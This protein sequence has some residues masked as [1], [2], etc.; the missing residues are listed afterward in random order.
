MPT[1]WEVSTANTK[2]TILYGNN[3]TNIYS[4]PMDPLG[5]SLQDAPAWLKDRCRVCGGKLSRYK[6]SYD[7]H[8]TTNRHSYGY[9]QQMTTGGSI[10]TDTAT[11]A[12]MSAKGQTKQS[13]TAKSILHDSQ[14]LNGGRIVRLHSGRSEQSLKGSHRKTITDH[15]RPGGRHQGQG[16]TKSTDG[17]WSERETVSPFLHGQ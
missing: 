13:K 7:A 2:K 12:T 6:V 9:S 17:S 10:H 16:T 5:D 11:G 8:T 3:V 15:T 14:S 1:F 4:R